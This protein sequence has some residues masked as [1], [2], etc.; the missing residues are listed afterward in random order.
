MAGA[1]R[2]AAL[3]ALATGALALPAGAPALGARPA[4]LSRQ[5]R[6]AL[7]SSRELWATIDVCHPSD[8]PHTIGIRGSM[9]GDGRTRDK[10]YMSFRLQ[11][12]DAT[13]KQWLDLAGAASK[14][15]AVG[16]GGSPRQGG[17]SFELMPGKTRFT[18]RGVVEFQ[19]RHGATVVQ[20]ASRPTG[21][22]HRSV[23]GSDPSGYSAASCT[24]G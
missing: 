15:I 4:P 9:P 12:Q 3:L 16:G 21:A 14:F 24:I 6:H 19:W 8:Q 13:S 20:S 10:M 2:T 1:G 11:Y 5:L 7:L 18:L 23:A 17:R 22:G